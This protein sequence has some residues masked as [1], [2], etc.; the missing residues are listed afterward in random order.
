MSRVSARVGRLSVGLVLCLLVLVSA[1]SVSWLA[2]ASSPPDKC[3]APAGVTCTFGVRYGHGGGDAH[4]L[5][6]YVPTGA[7]GEP[8]VVMVHGGGWMGGNSRGLYDEAVYFAQNGFAVFSVNYTLSTPDDPSWPTALADVEKAAGWVRSHADGYGADGSRLG[9][10][11]GSAGGHL[12]A[13]LDTA[14][15]EDGLPVLTSVA[16]SGPMDLG[17]TYRDGSEE[18]RDDV[19]QLLGCVPASCDGADVD[20]SPISHVTSGDGSVLFFNSSDELTPLSG[21]KAMN[22]RLKAAQVPHSLVVLAHTSR[23]AAEYECH[24]ATVLGQTDPV[25][26]GTLRWLGMYLEMPTT[27]TGTFCDGR[28]VSVA[29]SAG[30]HIHPEPPR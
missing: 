7:T 8:V 15:P 16:W 28:S 20:A 21:A 4:T 2:Q 13:L 23:H 10:F 18:M 24:P 22:K 30:P 11:G 1:G 12:A 26:D 6:V 3:T 17:L 5:D 29:R 25:I 14:G 9:V 19:E 27:P